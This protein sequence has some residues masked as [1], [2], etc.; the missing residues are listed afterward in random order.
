MVTARL[1]ELNSDMWNRASGTTYQ[2]ELSA[3]AAL[4]RYELDGHI[5]CGVASSHIQIN[6]EPVFQPELHLAHGN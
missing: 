5:N 2:K 1:D 4:A 3:S 6:L